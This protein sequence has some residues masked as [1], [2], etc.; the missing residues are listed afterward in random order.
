MIKVTDLTLKYRSGKGVFDLNFEIKKGEVVGYLGPNGAGKTTTIRALMGFI[1]QDD[2]SASINGLDTFADAPEIMKNLGYLP[3]EITFLEGMTG[4]EYLNYLAEV[5]GMKDL[6]RQREL[7][8]MFEFSPKGNIKKYSKGMKQKLGIVAAFMHDPDVLILDEPTS[9]L[10]PLMQ[11]RFV[12]LIQEEKRRGKTILMS[13]HMFEEIERT[14]D[15]V[16]IIKEGHLVAS[17]DIETLKNSQR[18]GYEIKTKDNAQAVTLLTKLGF[19]AKLVND[20]VEVYITGEST[21]QFIKS[22]SMLHIDSFDVKSQSLEDVFMH[23]YAKGAN[24]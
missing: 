9:G 2:G 12:E 16:L 21:D 14:C 22:C 13:S 6:K 7:I 24:V 1:K 5:R 17:A 20:I 8:K 15:H 3:G 10:D 4:E 18:K 11:N 19:D 23:Y